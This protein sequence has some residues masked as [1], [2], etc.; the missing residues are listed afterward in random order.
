MQ[1]QENKFGFAEVVDTVSDACKAEVKAYDVFKGEFDLVPALTWAIGE[2]GTIKEAIE[3]WP[4]FEQ[5][6][7]D[8]F[9]DEGIQA[10]EAI[11]AN[12][13]EREIEESRIYK[14]AVFSAVGYKNTTTVIE[15]GREQLALGAAIF[16]K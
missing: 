3:D 6:I 16:E 10:L 8:L 5:E 11:K 15:L 1:K 2:Y 13:T 4:V 9:A 7:K 12:L 14:L